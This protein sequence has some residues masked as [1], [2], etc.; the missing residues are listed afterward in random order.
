MINPLVNDI[1]CGPAFYQGMGYRGA[2]LS[3]ATRREEAYVGVEV[4]TGAYN[5]TV[6]I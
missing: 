5:C 6:S 3:R 1:R 4:I 2:K